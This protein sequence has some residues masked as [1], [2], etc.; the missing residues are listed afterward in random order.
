MRATVGLPVREGKPDDGR[1]RVDKA[2]T[3]QATFAAE[4]A[5]SR[6]NELALCGGYTPPNGWTSQRNGVSDQ[7][8]RLRFK[9]VHELNHETQPK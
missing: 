3:S 6:N 1:G 8:G 7:S 9:R 5:H 2:S 4:L